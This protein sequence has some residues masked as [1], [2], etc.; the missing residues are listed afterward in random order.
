MTAI[1]I[2]TVTAMCLAGAPLVGQAP[3][4]AKTTRVSP[5]AQPQGP[6]KTQRIT[7]D[8]SQN[9]RIT[10]LESRLDDIDKQLASLQAQL[11]SGGGARRPA[12]LTSDDQFPERPKQGK[13]NISDEVKTAL[14]NLWKA[15]D[16]IRNDIKAV[17]GGH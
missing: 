1:R 13:S 16:L 2:F 14:S 9:T 15:I 12:A 11:N 6:D 7:A 8:E 4:G 17:N 5:G 10:A 3:Q